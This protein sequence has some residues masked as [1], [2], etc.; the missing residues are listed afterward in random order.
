MPL[1]ISLGKKIGLLV[2]FG[3]V[4]IVFTLI[5]LGTR[6]G[7][8]KA[9]PAQTPEPTK[10][11]LTAETATQIESEFERFIKQYQFMFWHLPNSSLSTSLGWM[12]DNPIV[13]KGQQIV[14]PYK[15]TLIRNITNTEVALINNNGEALIISFDK[16]KIINLATKEEKEITQKER[17]S[18]SYI[19]YEKPNSMIAL[20]EDKK[21]FYLVDLISNQRSSIAQT[22]NQFNP[23]S[24]SSSNKTVAFTDKEYLYV[25]DN[26]LNKIK[27]DDTTMESIT[28]WL[29]D[30][31]YLVEKVTKPRVL[32]FLMLVDLKNR[33]FKQVITSSSQ[34]NRLNLKIRPSV[35]PKNDMVL[36]AEN[37]GLVWI[38]SKDQAITRIYPELKLPDEAWSNSAP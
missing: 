1:K 22:D 2:V 34:I 19:W 4:V 11:P 28:F 29:K 18:F 3:F 30:E 10:M 36:F 31:L 38:L 26:Q 5:I 17:E 20:S 16:Q 15:N 25:Y 7:R 33:Q 9:S 35:N 37:K 24:L 21:T 27:L 14:N 23:F 13:I 6:A 12:G 32:D 8:Q